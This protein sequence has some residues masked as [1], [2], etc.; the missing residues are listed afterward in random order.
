MSSNNMEN[1]LKKPVT[2]IY[3]D[4]EIREILE[5]DTIS[6]LKKQP[7]YAYLLIRMNKRIDRSLPVAGVAVVDG[8]I[9]LYINPEGYL[10]YTKSE[11]IAII[12]HEILH[13]ILLH[14][15]RRNGRD[16]SLWNVAA[17][18]AL[19][20]MVNTPEFKLPATALFPKHFNLPEGKTADEYYKILW[21]RNEKIEMPKELMDLL[22]KQLSKC[23]QCNGSG[24]SNG[25]DQNQQDG[26]QGEG[27][28]EGEGQDQGQGHGGGQGQP[29]PNCQGSGKKP[30]GG[31]GN[32]KAP[33]FADMHPTWDRSTDVSEEVAEGL[34]RSMVSEAHEKSIGDV[35]GSIA[36]LIKS[37]LESKINWRAIFRN[38]VA[39][40]RNTLRKSTW[41]R[42]NRRLG[43][44]VTGFKKSK[45]LQVA[46]F[47]DTSGSVSSEELAMFNGEMQKI[48]QAG[49][50]V[51]VIECDAAIQK[52]Y[53]YKKNIEPEFKG[54]GGTD[55]RPPFEYLK[56]H[57]MKPDCII[58]LT[59]GYGC[60]PKECHI[61]TLWV[62]TPQGRRPYSED[63]GDVSWGYDLT[64]E[65]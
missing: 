11:R 42:P 3:S 64:I 38:F 14:Y 12:I 29:C 48:Y 23:P 5:L 17:D 20:Q 62:L 6:L 46:V 33:D 1:V 41:K 61:P 45:K 4:A 19:N 47:V 22:G 55:F 36:E 27:E 54:R 43:Q 13:V 15:L 60:A 56:K 30:S 53:K 7:F 63:G 37:I 39:K 44:Q 8:E 18:I 59:D 16:A 57:G 25:Q 9:D 58:Y 51:D 65:D 21:K 10:E 24:Q 52:V 50:D 28:G 34:V 35:P 49:A 31:N 32:M 40:Q 26:G 2:K